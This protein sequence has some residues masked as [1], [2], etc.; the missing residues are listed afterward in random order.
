[1]NERVSVEDVYKL[2]R[3]LAR[4]LVRLQFG[5]EPRADPKLE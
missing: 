5:D 3:V 1:V 2:A 4:S